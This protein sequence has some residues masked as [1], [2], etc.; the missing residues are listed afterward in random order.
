MTAAAE[1]RPDVLEIATDWFARRRSGEMTPAE[2]DALAAWLAQDEAHAEAFAAAGRMWSA[3][4]LDA[5]REHP[6]ILALRERGLAR[7]SRRRWWMAAAPAA[8]AC[9]AALIALPGVLGPG[10]PTAPELL[11]PSIQ[12]EFR[13][14]VGQRTTVRLPD[15]S[16]VTLD[17]DTVLRTRETAHR[18]LI[19]LDKGQA[20]FK[21]A[22]D[23]SRPF[24]VSAGGRT[25]TA[26]GTAFSVR[27]AP[28]V[29]DVVLVEGSVRVESPVRATPLGLPTGRV[30]ATEMQAGSELA[31]FDNRH[32]TVR[33]ADPAAD[34][35]WLHGRLVYKAAPLSEVV[36]D[37]NRY[38]EKKIVIADAAVATRQLSGTYRAGDVEGFVKAVQ[39][40]GL[41]RVASNDEGEVEL[42]A[43]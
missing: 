2:T 36:A 27:V 39:D 16:L 29:F 3:S 26:T 21:V 7:R 14:S 37:M 11:A 5:I 33:E 8:A 28:K 13:T 12:Q 17:T 43:P 9:L 19:F 35:A 34:T 22:H 23:K 30:Q 24:V 10:L 1:E 31:A 41:A 6:Q 40:Y 25:V 4:G 18:R 38:S 20:F 32:W 42:T 15:G